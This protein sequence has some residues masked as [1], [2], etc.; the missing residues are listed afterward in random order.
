MKS[1]V[2]GQKR[3]IG[4]FKRDQEKLEIYGKKFVDFQGDDV[5]RQTSYST[6]PS[7]AAYC[8]P[9]RSTTASWNASALRVALRSSHC[10]NMRNLKTRWLAGLQHPHR[11]K[12]LSFLCIKGSNYQKDERKEMVVEGVTHLLSLHTCLDSQDTCQCISPNGFVI[13]KA[14]VG[15]FKALCLFPLN[16]TQNGKRV[17]KTF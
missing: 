14:L 15:V 16:R 1:K 8:V 3:R 5:N 13:E 12:Q 11:R 17:V 2:E 7:T 4:K 9:H 6:A 10:H